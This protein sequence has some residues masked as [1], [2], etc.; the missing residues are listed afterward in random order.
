MLEEEA[1]EEANEEPWRTSVPS[2]PA[3]IE[4]AAEGDPDQLKLALLPIGN[5]VRGQRD[6]RH[7]E[8]IAA[9]AREMLDN[10]VG[11]RAQD[12]VQK[13]IDDLLRNL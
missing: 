11:G 6:R 9:D 13:A 1:E 12:S 10:L 3:G 2:L 8:S 7:P 5:V 4:T